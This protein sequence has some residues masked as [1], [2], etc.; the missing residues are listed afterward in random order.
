M[1]RFVVSQGRLV[2]NHERTSKEWSAEQSNASPQP[3]ERLDCTPCDKRHRENFTENLQAESSGW[4]LSGK[5]VKAARNAKNES[6]G[7]DCSMITIAEHQR[8]SGGFE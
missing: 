4:R 2:S 8:C 7:V 1:S 5:S 6:R 3:P